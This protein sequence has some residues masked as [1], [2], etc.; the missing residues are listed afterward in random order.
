MKA[1]NP[2][3]EL[4]RVFKGS[5]QVLPPRKT[6]GR[7]SVD[8]VKAR[9]VFLVTFTLKHLVRGQKF[10]GMYP[11]RQ[12]LPDADNLNIGDYALLGSGEIIQIGK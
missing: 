9:D 11:T 4:T 7:P 1:R 8:L 10:L 6:K 2:V 5:Y 3:P 12:N